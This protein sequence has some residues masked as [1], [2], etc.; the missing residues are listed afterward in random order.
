MWRMR[1]AELTDE[2]DEVV[3]VVSV[4]WWCRFSGSF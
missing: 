3:S 1:N 2:P 4:V